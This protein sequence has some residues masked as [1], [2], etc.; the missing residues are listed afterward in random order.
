M[1]HLLSFL[2]LGRES[3]PNPL[4]YRWTAFYND[5]QRLVQDALDVSATDPKKS[6][7]FDVDHSRLQS[8]RLSAKTGRHFV[9]VNLQD[10]TFLVDGLQLVLNDD[11]I[12]EA[13][14]GLEL[15][16]FRRHFHEISDGAETSHRIVFRV[17]WKASNGVVRTLTFE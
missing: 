15:V 8:F 5:G 11:E 3:G 14:E 9:E 1:K 17:G 6:A 10:G 13:T 2:G 12:P 7:F 4:R 16:F